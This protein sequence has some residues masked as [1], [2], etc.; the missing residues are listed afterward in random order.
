MLSMF[1]H[2][3]TTTLGALVALG[4]VGILTP[5]HSHGLKQPSGGPE[6]ITNSV[7]MK[8]TIVPPGE[9]RIGSGESSEKAFALSAKNFAFHPLLGADDLVRVPAASRQASV[10]RYDGTRRGAE[11]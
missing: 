9:F 1:R 2:P 11:R 6:Q 4:T 3:C 8:P 5:A 10:R 7:G